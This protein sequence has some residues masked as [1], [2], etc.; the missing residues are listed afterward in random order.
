[1]EPQR[2]HKIKNLNK[3]SC[4]ICSFLFEEEIKD[5]SDISH[6]E[7]GDIRIEKTP[8]KIGLLK[9]IR[10]IKNENPLLYNNYV[11][12]SMSFPHI[13]TPEQFVN[14]FFEK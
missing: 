1:M 14:T 4:E 8:S 6:V 5:K 10:N 11:E 13:K 3:Q 9:I 2:T 7:I 12:C